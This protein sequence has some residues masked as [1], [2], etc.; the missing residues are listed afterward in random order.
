[1][2]IEK[3]V[4]TGTTQ[5][6]NAPEVYAFLNANKEGYFDSVEMDEMS[7]NIT[8][9]VGETPALTLGF[10]GTEKN[11]K[12]TL[13]NGVVYSTY[14]KTNLWKYAIK[15]SKGLVLVM[16]YNSLFITKSSTDTTAI[17]FVGQESS[18]TTSP[19]YKCA[20][21]V[22]SSAMFRFLYPSSDSITVTE[23]TAFVPI[24]LGANIESYA[25]DVYFTPYIQYKNVTSKL[26]AN[27]REYFYNGIIALGD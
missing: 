2:A 13:S 3:T 17:L 18:S 1:M 8:C 14:P 19:Y 27:G 23:F 12:I 5:A 26:T 6:A 22:H 15:T 7:H 11:V 24:P 20:D 9:Y 16:D 10:D 4:F 25:S 21:I